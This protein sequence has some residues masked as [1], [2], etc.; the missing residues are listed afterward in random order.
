M[1]RKIYTTATA[2]LPCPASL[3]RKAAAASQVLQTERSPAARE[4]EDFSLPRHQ[5]KPHTQIASSLRAPCF[6]GGTRSKSRRRRYSHQLPPVLP[7]NSFFS[8]F[9]MNFFQLPSPSL[10]FPRAMNQEFPSFA[11]GKKAVPRV[12]GWEGG[13]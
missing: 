11:L 7:K 13:R 9:Q 3:G 6:N 8:E 10:A 12:G 2:S 5:L 1:I 4:T